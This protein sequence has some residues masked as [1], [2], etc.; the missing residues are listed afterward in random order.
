MSFAD[1]ILRVAVEVGLSDE[2]GTVSAIPSDP[3]D[4]AKVKRAVNDGLALFARAWSRWRWM[5]PEVTLTM[6]P[7]GAASNCVPGTT[8]E[9]VLPWFCQGAPLTDWV[10][11]VDPN[12]LGTRVSST[13]IERVRA[14]RADGVDYQ[15]RPCMVAHVVH[16][17]GTRPLWK[18]VFDRDP[19]A[20]Y[21][22]T[23]R[24]R[25][26]QPPLVELDDRHLAGA[27]HDQ[28]IV[29]AGVWA[30]WRSK[31]EADPG[32]RGASEARF[33]RAVAESISL[34]SRQRET[35]LGAMCDPSTE[36]FLPPEWNQ[37]PIYYNGVL[38]N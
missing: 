35:N 16:Q 36:D 33:N 25:I 11:T 4:L 17:G 21:T 1:L 31:H 24:F 14:Y 18:A 37:A 9:Y 29:D 5:E 20:A 3:G 32:V 6:D 38:V 26:V 15:S 19:D 10:T 30:Y 27:Q 23:A 22:L 13:S 2:T 34:D 12:G 7:T 28:S 8:N